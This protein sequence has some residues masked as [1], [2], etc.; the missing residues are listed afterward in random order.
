MAIGLSKKSTVLLIFFFA[1]SFVETQAQTVIASAGAEYSQPSLRLAYTLGEPITQSYSLTGLSIGQGFHQ[2]QLLLNLNITGPDTVCPA[3]VNVYTLQGVASGSFNW[4]VSPSVG[5]TISGTGMS[6]NI[7][8]INTGTYVLQLLNAQTGITY[9]KNIFVSSVPANPTV[10][11]PTAVCSGG[12]GSYTAAS[13]G[14]SSFA[15]RSTSGALF[16]PDTMSNP[17]TV[18]VGAATGTHT[19]RVRAINRFGCLSGS[20]RAVNISVVSPPIGGLISGSL[21][22]CVSATATN[23]YT[24]SGISGNI[25]AYSWSATNS[26]VITGSGNSVQIRFPQAGAT[27]IRC[28]PRNSTCSG[29]AVVLNVTAGNCAASLTVSGPSKI[30]SGIAT[31]Y[32]ASLGGSYTWSLSPPASGTIQSGQGSD[33]IRVV[34]TANYAVSATNVTVQASPVSGT[35]ASRTTVVNNTPGLPVLTTSPIAACP[36]VFVNCTASSQAAAT[37]AW[38]V[39]YAAGSTASTSGSFT[40]TMGSRDARVQVAGRGNGCVGPYAFV[41]VNSQTGGCSK[42]DH[43]SN[44]DTPPSIVVYPNPAHDLIFIEAA[45][46]ATFKLFDLTGKC[47]VTGDFV[48]DKES[49]DL[50][51]QAAGVYQLM[52]Q[53]EKE[54][55]IYKIIKAQF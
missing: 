26:A 55:F 6:R 13:S 12:T 30:C 27:S 42:M 24:I 36:G 51:Q 21:T 16:S 17:V 28:V 31:G 37:Y 47:V 10:T 45:S 40:F 9:Q 8:I 14:A 7:R 5:V 25:T 34:F 49:L 43:E 32:K 15:W 46:G 48:G 35:P 39:L 44:M 2:P 29:E 54:K 3:A 1:L 11:G 50:S 20:E 53:K 23:T 4:T 41:T 19:I 38:G 18:S 33:S 52:I 22:P